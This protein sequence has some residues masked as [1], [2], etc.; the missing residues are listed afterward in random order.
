MSNRSLLVRSLVFVLALGSSALRPGLARADDIGST[1]YRKVLKSV[2]WIHSSRGG[3][4]LATGSGSLID[5][6]HR[7]VLTNY[8]VVGDNDRATVIFP[9][10][11]NG[12]LVAERDFYLERIRR[13][14]IRGKVVA[15]DRR[16]DLALIQLEDLS[17]GVETLPLAANSVVP[18]QSV[19]SIGNPGKSGAL[20]VYTPGRVRQV[21]FK[22][23][24]SDLEGRIVNFEA[25]VVET[26]S[27]TN[28]GDSGGP[29]VN[30]QGQ[31][32]GVT[33]G[34]AVN[35]QL[36]STF[37][38]VSE[39]KLFLAT[40]DVRRILGS[41]TLVSPR[42]AAD[43]IK[44]QAHLFSPEAIKKATEEL[45]DLAQRFE[46]EVVVETYPRVPAD[47]VDKVRAMSR[48]ERSKY[49][50][51]WASQR[52]RS[53]AINGVLILICKEPSHLE[54]QFSGHLRS[55]FSEKDAQRIAELMIARFRDKKFDEGLLE[56]IGAIRDKLAER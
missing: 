30:D 32:V 34:G 25:E 50:R 26:D 45:R 47:D 11:Q 53:A 43:R 31:L 33:Q 8:H 21:Y 35:A 23:W 24:K 19:Q 18:G 51:T 52:L 6:K 17:D 2:V 27:A 1:V 55:I 3:G 4:K 13:D 20:W 9:V 29:L 7:L 56:A 14:G 15:R 54:V 28:P 39:V 5:R 36:L 49:F 44:D 22:K 10:F 42:P 41:D 48:E 16:C 40:R 46:R 12:K 38:D 37:I